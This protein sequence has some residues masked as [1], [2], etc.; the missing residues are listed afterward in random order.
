MASRIIAQMIVQGVTLFGRVFISAYQQA[1]HNAKAGGGAAAVVR[2][3]KMTP[4]EALKI[5]NI[6]RS[7]LNKEILESNYKKYYD[8]NDPGKGGSFYLQSKIY[9]AK[10]ALDRELNGETDKAAEDTAKSADETATKKEKEKEKGK[11]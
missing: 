7:G 2:K 10:E 11:K 5:L 3:L 1:L 9:R 4:D 8:L 6:E